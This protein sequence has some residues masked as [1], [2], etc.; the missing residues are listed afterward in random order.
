[1]QQMDRDR[2][3]NS[4]PNPRPNPLLDK[5]LQEILRNAERTHRRQLLWNR[6]RGTAGV[7]FGRAGRRGW[8]SGRLIGLA[9]GCWLLAALIGRAVPGL[10]SVLLIG[11]VVLFFYALLRGA[12]ARGPGGER[13][14]RGRVIEYQQDDPLAG[15]RNWLRQTMARLRGGPPPPPNI[16]R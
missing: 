9:I 1:M 14:W 13:I 12:G 3:K 5:Q 16:R 10:G 11:G 15:A 7:V 6:V 8:T 2:E 4:G